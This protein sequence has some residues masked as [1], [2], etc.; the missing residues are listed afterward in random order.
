[1]RK[2]RVGSLRQ[3]EQFRQMG[4]CSGE[5]GAMLERSVSAAKVGLAL[6]IGWHTFE[7]LE[8]AQ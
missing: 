3:R 4:V 1:M 2:V 7:S 8:E 5:V 6:R